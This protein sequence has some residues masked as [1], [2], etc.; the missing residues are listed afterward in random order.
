M[1]VGSCLQIVS[2]KNVY[3]KFVCSCLACIHSCYSLVGACVHS[4]FNLGSGAVFQ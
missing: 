2:G 3:T 4:V 1:L